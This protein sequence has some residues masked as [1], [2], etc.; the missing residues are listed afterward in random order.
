V[1]SS[2]RA[3]AAFLLLYGALLAWQLDR[4][5]FT[6]HGLVSTWAN[7]H[8]G[9]TASAAS[10]GGVSQTFGMGADA[11]D[12]VWLRPVVASGVPRGELV[13]DLLLQGQGA[14][15]RRLERVAI[16]ASDVRDVAALHVPFRPI[17]AS[18]GLMYQVNVR[19]M[20]LADGPAIDLA[21]TR[22][23]ALRSGRLFVDGREQWGDLVFETS[24]RRATLVYW[25][26]EILRPWPAWV[27]AWPAIILGLLIVNGVLAWACAMAVGLVGDGGVVPAALAAPD[28]TTRSSLATVVV[29]LG[30]T[31]GVAF[32][33]RPTGREYSLDLIAALPDARVEATWGAM[34]HVVSHGPVWFDPRMHQSIVAMPPST[35][36]WTVEVPRTATLRLGAAMRPD[37][38]TITGDGIQM[39]VHID[40]AGGRTTVADLTLYPFIVIEHRR[41]VPLEIPLQRWAGQRVVVVLETT[42]EGAGN[43][44]N[45]VPVW[46]EPRIEWSRALR[47]DAARVVEP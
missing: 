4:W 40:H 38:W 25:L 18:R 47:S 46:T 2:P 22:D 10:P 8:D 41:L 30:T 42:P 23:D 21:T 28:R 37:M 13:V 16:P 34:H 1:R 17:R 26:P 43:A 24:S 45:D 11:L 39:R 36:A 35:I 31:L 29:L 5:C 15:L 32:A 14:A 19:H 7:R 33:G 44:V 6:P 27:Q 3:R 12:G 9:R 20:H